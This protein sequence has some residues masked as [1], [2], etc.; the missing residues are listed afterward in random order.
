M[1]ANLNIAYVRASAF[2]THFPNDDVI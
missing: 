2:S 1:E